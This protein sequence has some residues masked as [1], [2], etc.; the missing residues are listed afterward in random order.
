MSFLKVAFALPANAGLVVRL[1]G[2]VVATTTTSNS[3]NNVISVSPIED[4]LSN[5]S[6]S[7]VVDPVDVTL[8]ESVDNVRSPSEHCRR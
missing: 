6:D 4:G 2:V 5:A 7:S 1:N 3:S 8:D